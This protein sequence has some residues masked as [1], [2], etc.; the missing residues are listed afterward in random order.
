MLSSGIGRQTRM[1]NSGKELSRYRAASE[2]RKKASLICSGSLTV[3]SA[4]VL[5]LFLMIITGLLLLFDVMAFQ[6][7]LQSAVDYAAQ[8]AAAY[9]YAVEE[10]QNGNAED[11]EA[12]ESSE[13]LGKEIL[14]SGLTALYLQRLITEQMEEEISNAF[15]LSGGR[16]GLIVVP[17]KFPDQDGMIDLCVSY[18]VKIPFL[19]E[20]FGK[21][22]MAQRSRRKVWSGTVRWKDR[23]K[24]EEEKEETYVF[25][26]E[27]GSVYHTVLTCSYL[28]LSIRAVSEKDVSALRNKNGEKYSPCEKCGKGLIGY[29][30]YITDS[31]NRY[32]SKLSCSALSRNIRK[33]LLSEAEGYRGC[34]RCAN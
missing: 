18:Q 9:Y 23:G 6:L 24:E 13:G 34:S 5:P 2:S 3:E 30:V 15:W 28:K 10:V 12:L 14:T 26:T 27:H 31:G 32:H 19:P 17:A 25:V 11:R 7:K 33:I 16:N 20:A 29:E 8:K 1:K 21:L 4:L 22:S